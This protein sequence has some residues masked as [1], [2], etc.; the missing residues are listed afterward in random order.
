MGTDIS[1][2]TKLFEDFSLE[3]LKK[4]W[5][6]DHMR[7]MFVSGKDVSLP[8]RYEVLKDDEQVNELLERSIAK[9]RSWSK[10]VMETETSHGD[11]EHIN[12]FNLKEAVNSKAFICVLYVYIKQG[13]KPN[14]DVSTRCLSLKAASLY[15]ISVS[16][17][18]SQAF[19]IFQTGI[20]LAVLELL[21]NTAIKFNTTIEFSPVVSSDSYKLYSCAN[22]VLDCLCIALHSIDKFVQTEDTDDCLQS[23]MH[24][25]VCLTCMG[26]K[27]PSLVRNLSHEASVQQ[28]NPCIAIAISAYVLIKKFLVLHHE[29]LEAMMNRMFRVI[30]P[31][32]NMTLTS[33][34]SVDLGSEISNVRE[35]WTCFLFSLIEQHELEA[36]RIIR[37]MLQKIFFAVHDS[38][39]MRQKEIRVIHEIMMKLDGTYFSDMVHWFMGACYNISFQYRSFALEILHKLLTDETRRL[40]PCVCATGPVSGSKYSTP[41]YIIGIMINRCIDENPGVKW[42]VF[43]IL[44]N[45]MTLQNER[46]KQVFEKIFVT[47]YQQ[48][49]SITGSLQ[50]SVDYRDI[51]KDSTLQPLPSGH[52]F[53]YLI[54]RALRHEKVLY[55]KSALQLLCHILA[56]EPKWAVYE[57]S[58]V[59]L[60]KQCLNTHIT[61]RKML[62]NQF[63]DIV[64]RHPGNEI[65]IEHWINGVFTLVLDQEQKMQE[66]VSKK[67]CSLMLGNLETYSDNLTP[68]KKLP[69]T[70]LKFLA[71]KGLR[72]NLS[73]CIRKWAQA[74]S[75]KHSHITTLY[76]YLNTDYNNLAWFFL[77]TIAQSCKVIT[78]VDV[79][80]KYYE[81]NIHLKEVQDDICAPMVMETLG[82]CIKNIETKSKVV[83]MVDQIKEN[84]LS[85]SL[86]VS[87]LTAAC[88][89]VYIGLEYLDKDTLQQT[90]FDFFA[91]IMDNI[92]QHIMSPE[93]QIRATENEL[94]A[95]KLYSYAEAMLFCP[96]K[97][98]PETLQRLEKHLG[99]GSSPPSSQMNAKEVSIGITILMRRGVKSD[100]YSQQILPSLMK[101][102]YR[103]RHPAVKLN[104]L[105]GLCDQI[106]NS[107]NLIDALMPEMYLYLKDENLRLR[108]E[109]LQMI[110]GWI[111]EDFLRI[112][113]PLYFFLAILLVDKNTEVK[114]AAFSFF[115]NCALMKDPQICL[116]YF[117]VC[118]FHFNQYKGHRLSEHILSEREHQAYYIG[119]Q[120][121]GDTRFLIYK[122]MLE[123]LKDDQKEPLLSNLV[124]HII[125]GI[126]AKSHDVILS[127]SGNQL[128]RDTLRIL[129]CEELYTMSSGKAREEDEEEREETVAF[130]SKSGKNKEVRRIPIRE[131][132]VRNLL[133]LRSFL[134]RKSH[135]MIVEYYNMMCLLLRMYKSEILTLISVSGQMVE[136]KR[137]LLV[138]KS[139]HKNTTSRTPAGKN[140]DRNIENTLQLINNY[141]AGSTQSQGTPSSTSSSQ[142]GNSSVRKTSTSIRKSLKRRRTEQ[143][144]PEDKENSQT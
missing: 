122:Y 25:L 127:E 105:H 85:Y 70:I 11:T 112:Q 20:Y 33:Y 67:L 60:E 62:V 19:G 65:L 22:Q 40:V 74:K 141:Q 46:I 142:N 29:P 32:Y 84:I 129:S 41:E 45:L 35:N 5:V 9:L 15:L 76:T 121:N 99:L 39:S 18:S 101:Y 47:P 106:F 92:H 51:M 50:K 77:V 55:R 66:E 128:L 73:H 115:V 114:R 14:A 117:L 6:D 109:C 113:T 56:M 125:V 78:D 119:G 72:K 133:E 57:N 94:Q 83:S 61:I 96:S 17:H 8:H 135:P 36:Y 110:I 4:E 49:N 87:L 68:I 1:E 82:C 27:S 138:W 42:K 81:E 107:P 100:E 126:T 124:G 69:F 139:A 103:T 21:N 144:R 12:W 137:D 134:K 64:I 7:S 97:V 123:L 88:N 48:E 31:L 58:V 79:I 120:S 63:T 43:S 30:R 143:R 90:C 2:L 3:Q 16:I 91:P 24:T 23:T 136:L 54:S 34:L 75:I 111:K 53:I 132:V 26:R 44:V 59:I 102:L 118:I 38:A 98:K 71:K 104:I 80:Y 89:T 131:K 93:F 140:L 37:I 108:T 86:P 95:R 10:H 130:K 116:K 13:L 52:F 28:P